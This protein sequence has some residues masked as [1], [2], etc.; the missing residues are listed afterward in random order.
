MAGS[1]TAKGD[2]K[3]RKPPAGSDYYQRIGD[4]QQNLRDRSHLKY[5]KLTTSLKEICEWEKRAHRRNQEILKD[6]DR[7]EAH[8]RSLTPS[9]N[10][11][12]QMKSEYQK[13]MHRKLAV[14]KKSAQ[15][16]Y[17]EENDPSGQMLLVGQQ[18]GINLSLSRGSYHPAT[19]FMSRQ[20]SAN[21]SIEHSSTQ[22][23]SSQPTKSFSIPDPNSC[24]QAAKS[25]SVTDSSVMQTNS[26]DIQRLN[27]SDKIDGKPSLQISKKAS[28]TSSLS[29]EHEE[30][31]S[32]AID[33]V[34]SNRSRSGEDEPSAKPGSQ[35]HERLSPENRNK[36][37]KYYGPTRKVEEALA[38][39]APVINEE[40]LERRHPE[41]F[42]GALDSVSEKSSDKHEAWEVKG[43]DVGALWPMNSTRELDIESLDSSS[44]LTVSVSDSDD[45]VTPG[46]PLRGEQHRDRTAAP[47]RSVHTEHGG[48]AGP[49]ILSPH[50]PEADP[51]SDLETSQLHFSE[52]GFFHL[53]DS[54][55][56]SMHRS[57]TEGL[58]LYQGTTISSA[59]LK[60]LVCL[61]NQRMPLK[62]EDLGACSAV[63]LQQFQR[64]LLSTDLIDSRSTDDKQKRFDPSLDSITFQDRLYKHALFLK[65]RHVSLKENVSEILIS[66]LALGIYDKSPKMLLLPEKDLSE[67]TEE[68]SSFHSHGSPCSL[69]SIL[70]DNGDVKQAKPV[71]LPAS[72]KAHPHRE[73]PG[74]CEDERHEDSLPEKIPITVLERVP[75]KVSKIPVEISKSLSEDENQIESI[76][77]VSTVDPTPGLKFDATT[78][79][80]KEG[81]KICSEATASSSERSPLS[82]SEQ[83]QKVMPSTKSKAFWGESD[84]ST[85]DIEDVLRPQDQN[86]D[87]DDFDDFYD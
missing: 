59:K 49:S 23:K 17:D 41:L 37:L 83:K 2:W 80:A 26:D 72:D 46:K 1:V 32:A 10:K 21:S 40:R 42:P 51:A 63:V 64:L 39:E 14:L 79:K 57:D 35:L 15:I 29:S 56:E 73:A 27:M 18:T 81:S 76:S 82:R 77:D 47:G 12:Q 68:V 38:H 67:E 61:S 53:L 65:T 71:Q 25:S 7:I 19:I 28:P 11:L 87:A 9:S 30:T 62:E 54:V 8:V 58:E 55:E 75:Q 84:D 13:Y 74:W 66:F 43:R 70:S 45:D 20:V 33:G 22:H 24:R 78:F 69:L 3:Q 4:L 85:S 52:E 31:H 5:V 60:E 36:D 86:A 6:F 48:T 50:V 44:D 34:T 16:T